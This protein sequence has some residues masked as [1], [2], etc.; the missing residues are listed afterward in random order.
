MKK[1]FF[2]ICSSFFILTGFNSAVFPWPGVPLEGRQKTCLSCHI[3]TGPWNDEEKTII[4]I[5]DPKTGTSFKKP[6]GSFAIP[7]KKGEERR[8][9]VVL[10]VEPTYSW[11]PEWTAW[12]FVHPEALQ[13]DPESSPKFAPNW[14]VNRAFCGKRLGE[15][16]K[17]FEEKKVA[18]ITMTI[19]PL[20]DAK[21]E[22]VLLQ[23]FFKSG[24][25]T[26]V[27]NY[28]ERKVLLQ[29]EG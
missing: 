7:V 20:K 1:T 29:V 28:F 19:R 4:E 5:L 10:G 17:G 11:I 26:K 14:E 21:D 22:T 12:L 2:S 13:K 25:R 24:D 8:V 23:V 9:L 3:N 6:D 27:G 18:S 15:S 16:V